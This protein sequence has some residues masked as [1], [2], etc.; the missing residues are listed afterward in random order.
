MA[1]GQHSISVRHQPA[2]MYV[3]SPAEL[4]GRIFKRVTT[5]E[6]DSRMIIL[7]T[8][9]L[10]QNLTTGAIDFQADVA[11]GLVSQCSRI[12]SQY[13]RAVVNPF[14]VPVGSPQS[15]L[16]I[17]YD[18]NNYP[19]FTLPAGIYTINTYIDAIVAHMTGPL[20]LTSVTSNADP[21]TKS[22]MIGVGTGHTL[23]ITPVGTLL[24][25]FGTIR[26]NGTRVVNFQNMQMFHT[27]YFTV[28][29]MISSSTM[30]STNVG[31]SGPL[32]TATV[33][34]YIDNP[35]ATAYVQEW[36]WGKP[37]F[38]VPYDGAIQYMRI[39]CFDEFGV[40]LQVQPSDWLCIHL[41]ATA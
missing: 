18:T 13:I 27:R 15:M 38:Q 8:G 10:G 37:S 12:Y 33:V 40:L 31:N 23:S 34:V 7:D 32:S 2:D 30:V 35:T 20:A 16:N 39:R 4:D 3:Y 29:L 19:T 9:S 21:N 6:P 11:G 41:Y 17:V 1:S 24:P 28:Q 26:N 25:R 5:H 14:N 36:L 22:G